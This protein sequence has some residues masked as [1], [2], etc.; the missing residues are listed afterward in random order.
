MFKIKLEQEYKEVHAINYAKAGEDSQDLLDFLSPLNKT[1]LTAAEQLIKTNIQNADIITVC[2]GAN[3]ILGP[4]T[5]NLTKYLMF[6]TDIT[7][8]LDP[9]ITQLKTNLPQIVTLLTT[10]NPTA[11]I[12][13]L[14]VFNPYL[15]LMVTETMPP[16][17]GMLSVNTTKLKEIGVIT[18]AYLN[19]GE[20]NTNTMNKTV[21]DGVNTIIY[22]CIKD[23]NNCHLLDVN[24]A[25]NN[26]L[27][28]NETYDI[29]NVCILSRQN[30]SLSNLS[31]DLDPHPNTKGHKLIFDTLVSWYTTNKSVQSSEE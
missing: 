3:D 18:E 23:Q 15:E 26:Y 17:S 11:D 2:I 21:P 12:V 5:N 28:N 27:T 14:N 25:F 7:T 8:Y 16:S 19:S 1:S 6:G 31:T 22:D 10:L 29:V 4:A 13:F 20:I 30:I 9:G 24:S